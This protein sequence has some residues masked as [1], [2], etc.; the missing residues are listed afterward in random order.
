MMRDLRDGIVSLLRSQANLACGRKDVILS[1]GTGYRL[2]DLVS[3]HHAAE[4]AIADITDT[5]TDITDTD[6]S[7]SVPNVRGDD[8]RDVRDASAARRAW[9]L[10]QLADGVQLKAPAVAE[11][12]KCSVKTA[13]RQL[14]A[15]KDEGK[16]EYVGAPRTGYYQLRPPP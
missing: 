9:I 8:V 6:E 1:G 10:Q 2:S 4:S 7:A 5:D 15:L 14:T 3:V 16:I 12:F 13:Q 11:H